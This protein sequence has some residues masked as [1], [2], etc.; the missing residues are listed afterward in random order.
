MTKT[1]N[2]IQEIVCNTNHPF[3]QSDSRPAKS[4]KNRYERRKIREFLHLGD[5]TDEADVQPEKSFKRVRA[6]RARVAFS[7]LY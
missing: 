4:Q 2:L 5:W 7:G 1:L 6:P 3:R